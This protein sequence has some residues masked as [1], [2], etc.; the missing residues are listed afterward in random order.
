MA[1]KRSVVFLPWIR[2]AEPLKSLNVELLPLVGAYSRITDQFELMRHVD[3]VV[4][5][6]HLTPLRADR[7]C[8]VCTI[9][10]DP[11]TSTNADGFQE[12]ALAVRVLAVAAIASNE[13][14]SHDNYVNGN[15]FAPVAQRFVV[16]DYHAAFMS[17]RRDGGTNDMGYPYQHLRTTA[18]PWI[19]QCRTFKV[20]KGLMSA[21]AALQTAAPREFRRFS[22]AVEWFL[23]SFSDDPADSLEIEISA[24]ATAYDQSHQSNMTPGMIYKTFSDFGPA[25]STIRDWYTQF[26]KHRDTIVHGSM[27]ARP[28]PDEM[29]ADLFL[30]SEVLMAVW[31]KFF[32]QRGIYDFTDDDEQRVDRILN[33][34]ETNSLNAW[35][36]LVQAARRRAHRDMDG[37]T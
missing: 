36:D 10:H 37:M 9:S 14:L 1:E 26:R 13:Y 3:A 8:V 24:L 27:K 2:L 29:A 23:K 11:F 4:T 7:D 30:G 16:G 18:P 31:K 32:A 25:A 19:R 33:V 22:L 6:Y 5:E 15:T 28:K 17:R 12:I 34:M 20:N 21:F 35:K